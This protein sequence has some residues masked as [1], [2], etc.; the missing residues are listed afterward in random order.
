[1]N[2][3]I[4]P[5]VGDAEYKRTRLLLGLELVGIVVILLAAPLM[6]RAVGM[7]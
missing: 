4:A 2:Q 3:N 1:L 5:L 6:A 7:N